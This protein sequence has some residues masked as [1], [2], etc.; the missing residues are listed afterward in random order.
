MKNEKK[1]GEIIDFISIWLERRGGWNWWG[2]DIF[3][4]DLL[5]C[6]P[7]ELRIKLKRKPSQKIWT[8]KPPCIVQTMWKP[9]C[10]IVMFLF[11]SFFPLVFFFFWLSFLLLFCFIFFISFRFLLSFLGCC[12][13][14]VLF[15]HSIFFFFFHFFL[16]PF[17]WFIIFLFPSNLLLLFLFLSN[18]DMRVNL[19]LYK[20]HFLS[21]HFSSQPNKIVFHPF[22][23]PSFKPNT[24]EEKLNLFYPLTFLSLP[25]EQ[26]LR[27]HHCL[28]PSFSTSMR[29][30]WFLW[31]NHHTKTTNI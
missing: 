20:L 7:L 30:I 10:N 5:K 31:A 27:V 29:V 24:Y 19:F 26:T 22:T 15:I 28:G 13:F 9:Q 25:T 16:F 18:K 21:S 8:K 11:F 12:L 6:F 3:F 23:L 14:Q 4:L 1:S 2:L 17:F